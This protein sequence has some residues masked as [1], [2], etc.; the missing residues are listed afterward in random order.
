MTAR[1]Y[2]SE[3]L[4]RFTINSAV[5]LVPRVQ[6]TKSSVQIQLSFFSWLLQKGVEKQQQKQQ[7]TNKIKK[8]Q[9]NYILTREKNVPKFKGELKK[10]PHW[11]PS[12]IY[13]CS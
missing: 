8:Y 7:Q 10:D 4:G 3:K 2:H 9:G 5:I 12:L 6:E 11:Q 13:P 1:F